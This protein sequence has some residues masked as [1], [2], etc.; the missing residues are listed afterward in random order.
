LPVPTESTPR[1]QK[2][3][4]IISLL[5]VIVFA[6]A[7]AFCY[8]ASSFCI[9]LILASFLSILI[10]PVIS[11]LERWHIPRSVSAALLIGLSLVSIL[12]LTYVSYN[13]LST[14][15]DSLPAYAARIR[16]MVRPLNDKITKVQES[17][18]S[19]SPEVPA[20]KVP[21]VKIRQASEWPSY[22]A[23]GFG[24]VSGTILILGVL[25]F[26]MFFML[27]R[28][29]KW[30]QTVAQLL[31]PRLDAAEFANRLAQ[32]VRRFAVGNLGIGALLSVLTIGILFALKIQGAG[33]L[34]LVS[35]MLNLIP[36]VGFVF[37]AA[38]PLFAAFLQSAPVSSLV[39]IGIAITAFHLISANFLIPRFIGPRINI[40]PV[41]ATAGILFW[42]WLWGVMGILLAIPLTGLVKLI[43]DCH[44]SLITLSNMLGESEFMKRGANEETNELRVESPPAA[45]APTK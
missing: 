13:R 40:G 15:A 6:L 19:L 37:A 34:G 9:T 39:I 16:G 11:F 23:T 30:Y 4:R 7:L 18:G 25:P 8:F 38:V 41:A 43:A 12:F 26:L 5:W 21:E 27:I 2:L 20:K 10:D 3:R 29:E 31:G 22:L 45:V 35:G 32:M 44:P 24:S 14:I 33:I 36:Y 28:K 42:G 1:N 17:A